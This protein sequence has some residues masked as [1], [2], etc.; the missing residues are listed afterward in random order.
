MQSE[1]PNY[2]L[3]LSP[4]TSSA[5]LWQMYNGSRPWAGLSHGQIIMSV[6]S[7]VRLTFPSSAPSEFAAL[8]DACMAF[9][10]EDRPSFEEVLESL[11][12]MQDSVRTW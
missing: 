7:H 12:T 9:K 5:Q 6:V 1:Q 8:A 10:P 2:S 11:T 4:V 3:I